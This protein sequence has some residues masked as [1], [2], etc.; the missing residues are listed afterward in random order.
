MASPLAQLA[1]ILSIPVL[2]GVV[3]VVV[4]LLAGEQAV[5]ILSFVVTLAVVGAL[6]ALFVVVGPTRTT[7]HSEARDDT[8][9]KE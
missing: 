5:S 9:R 7:R 2:L 6:C 1:L 4:Y 3:Q 8:E